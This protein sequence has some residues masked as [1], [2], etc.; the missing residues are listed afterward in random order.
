MS[1]QRGY[2]IKT[3]TAEFSKYLKY[4]QL[5]YDKTL[6]IPKILDSLVE[7]DSTVGIYKQRLDDL[8]NEIEFYTRTLESLV[9]FEK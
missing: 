9:P 1:M 4:K 2:D 7:S 8:F 6:E 5:E 3:D